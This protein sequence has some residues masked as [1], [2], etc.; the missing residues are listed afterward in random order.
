MESAN[1]RQQQRDVLDQI[2]ASENLAL[3]NLQYALSIQAKMA[4]GMGEAINAFVHTLG[5]PGGYQSYQQQFGGSST[6][7]STKP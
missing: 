7:T 6:G 2:R 3:A 1:T 5:Q 4:H